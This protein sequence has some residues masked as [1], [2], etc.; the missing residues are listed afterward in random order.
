MKVQTI[1]TAES[2]VGKRRKTIQDKVVD[3][4]INMLTPEIEIVLDHISVK[5]S[6]INAT[7]KHRARI[8]KA[9]KLLGVNVRVVWQYTK[10]MEVRQPVV[11]LDTRRK[12]RVKAT[13]LSGVEVID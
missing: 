10:D 9:G 7:Q 6:D 12:G 13:E 4:A 3:K 2:K 8:L 11:M 1:G 5:P